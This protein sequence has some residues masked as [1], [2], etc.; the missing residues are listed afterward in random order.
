[1]DDRRDGDGRLVADSARRVLVDDAAAEQ[2][3]HVD[4]VAAVDERFGHRK[5]LGGRQPTEG[6]GHAER[7]HLVVGDVA[8]RLPEH[9]LNHLLGR[10]LA[11]VAFPLYELGRMDHVCATKIVCRLCVTSGSLSSGTRV[12]RCARVIVIEPKWRTAA[13]SGKTSVPST[14][15][16]VTVSKWAAS[17]S[18]P[19]RASKPRSVLTAPPTSS[20][21][22]R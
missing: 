19:V 13:A 5:R 16:C 14:S 1:G 4:A 15:R 6:D 20:P 8:R 11:A 18:R 12:A 10:D 2:P 17:R 3:S 7:G 22:S 21:T 9:E